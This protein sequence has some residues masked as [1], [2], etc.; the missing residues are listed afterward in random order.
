MDMS[1]SYVVSL[2][3]QVFLK[4]ASFSEDSERDLDE[5]YYRQQ[6]EQLIDS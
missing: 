6:M 5:E 4:V 1:M 2:M 3:S